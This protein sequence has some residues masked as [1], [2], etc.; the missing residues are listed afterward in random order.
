[1]VFLRN[2]AAACFLALV[3]VANSKA[4]PGP[5][6]WYFHHSELDS[7]DALRWSKALIDRAATA[8]YT[9]VVLWCGGIDH[10]GDPDWPIEN[11]DRLRAALKYAASKH[12]K[13]VVTAA[14]FANSVNPPTRQFKLGRSSEYCWGGVSGG[15]GSPNI[16]PG[17]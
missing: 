16:A 8:G 1:M 9:G 7:D 10:A 11:E 14:P 13:T 3:G 15:S 6:L 17:E 12:L 2:L 4:A 5:E